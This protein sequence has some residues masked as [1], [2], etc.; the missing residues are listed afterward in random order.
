MSRR[1]DRVVALY[2]PRSTGDGP[3]NARALREQLEARARGTTVE[4]HETQ[5][6]G[7]AEEL[8]E[9]AVTE[10]PATL[11]VSASGDGGYHEVVNGV[12]RARRR[13]PGAGVCAVLASGNANDHARAVQ[14]RPLVDA[15][16]AGATSEM[17]LL[18]VLVDG[19]EPRYAHSYV[20]LGITPVV[21]VEFNQ[22]DLDAVKESALAVR[23]VWR[24][25]PLSIV[26]D[27]HRIEL[28]S[29]VFANIDRMAKYA[30][31]SR[32]SSPTDGTYESLLIRHRSKLKLLASVLRV[33]RGTHEVAS[34]DEP[35]TFTTG[36]PMPLQMDGEVHRVDAGAT[37]TV[38]C[39]AGALTV[40]R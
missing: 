11:V 3:G 25:R 8:A 14:D 9:R 12:V 1:F 2:N 21:A 38:R 22:H 13:C 29:L 32:V 6:A 15:I 40:V 31:L 35:Y 34:R 18:E 10:H 26:H 19:R 28:D 36:T 4:L 5:H 39:V 16:V 24:Y 20:G 27:G 17:D 30:T 37:V 7:H 23:S 33:V